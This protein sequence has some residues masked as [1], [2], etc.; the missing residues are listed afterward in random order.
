MKIKK[1]N[2]QLF[3][4][5]VTAAAIAAAV[6]SIYFILSSGN[7]DKS[8]AKVTLQ[9]IVSDPKLPDKEYDNLDFS[10]AVLHIPDVD[11]LYSYYWIDTPGVFSKDESV[12]A[13]EELFFGIFS[14]FD[15]NDVVW[16]DMDGNELPG[17]KP[18]YIIG[19]CAADGDIWDKNGKYPEYECVDR[20]SNKSILGFAYLSVTGAFTIGA[21]KP[22]E[23]VYGMGGIESKIVKEVKVDIGQEIP[24]ET[25]VVGGKEY[26]L[27]QAIEFA[28]KIFSENKKFFENYNLKLSVIE[29]IK[30]G[31]DDYYSY[32]FSYEATYK[33]VPVSDSDVRGISQGTG[34]QS[35]KFSLIITEPDKIANIDN[36]SSFYCSGDDGELDDKF[37]TLESAT[38]LINEF[39]APEYKHKFD[40][41]TIKYAQPYNG[42]TY[43][44]E[45]K[46]Y[47]RPY[48]CFI[49]YKDPTYNPDPDSP[50][51]GGIG[52]ELIEDTIFVDM[53][54]GEILF[55]DVLQHS[56]IRSTDDLTGI[57]NLR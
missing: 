14:Y 41:V 21:N 10:D 48:W 37:I 57:E 5:G 53:Q 54:T 56:Y 25:Y 32:R 31:S 29:I 23:S 49:T 30:N 52:R 39:F 22:Y 4:I 3:I 15:K 8:S 47:A 38:D 19:E 51:A 18:K 50:D 16:V 44:N 13:A 43:A 46:I 27:K 45:E 33:G 42:Q 26:P 40:E 36:F 55:F 11:K 17:N 9:E 1:K 35:P 12:D 34:M 20:W 28:E 7:S 6:V 24:D 2:K